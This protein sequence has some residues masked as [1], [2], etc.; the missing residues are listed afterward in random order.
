MSNFLQTKMV[1]L[2]TVALFLLSI[3][4]ACSEEEPA[5]TI[6][7]IDDIFLSGLD[8]PQRQVKAHPGKQFFQRRLFKGSTLSVYALGSE[9]VTNEINKFPIDEFVYY[10]NGRA[11]ILVKDKTLTFYAGDYLAVPKGFSGTW[12]NNGGPNHHLELSVIS[13]TRATENSI[14][15][16]PRLLDRALLSGVSSPSTKIDQTHILYEGPEL[17]ITTEVES[18]GETHVES[19]NQETFIHVLNGAVTIVPTH[20]ESQQ[21]F[22]GDFFILAENFSGKWTVKGS[23]GLRTLKVRAQPQ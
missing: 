14:E 3:G 1:T 20:G 16:M 10:L 21:F 8:L 19:G 23:N 7:K 17:V 12:T 15:T 6:V 4:H 9:T 13:N 11:D 18:E 5:P 22:K 2:V